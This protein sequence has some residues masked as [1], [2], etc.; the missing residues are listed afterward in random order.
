MYI[1]IYIYTHTRMYIYIYILYY[2]LPVD[3]ASK[4][5]HPMPHENGNILRH[6]VMH[7]AA[8]YNMRC[9]SAI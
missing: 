8:I 6:A 3:T 4:I 2:I 9:N 1:Y 7:Y 5:V